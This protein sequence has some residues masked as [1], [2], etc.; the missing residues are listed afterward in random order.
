ME[1]LGD[2]LYCVGN[3]LDDV[4]TDIRDILNKHKDAPKDVIQD[5]NLI[6]ETLY[7]FSTLCQDT[8]YDIT[9]EEDK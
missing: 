2:R 7:T 6:Q 3:Q 4:I 8:A 5:L 9:P 1:E